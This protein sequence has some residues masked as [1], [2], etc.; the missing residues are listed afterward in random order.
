MTTEEKPLEL[1][2]VGYLSLEGH[3]NPLLFQE[4]KLRASQTYLSFTQGFETNHGLHF[5]SF[6]WCF[7]SV[8][9]GGKKPPAIARMIFLS[10]EVLTNEEAAIADL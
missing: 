3:H 4:K 9:S 8:S 10:Y 5:R 2:P 7:N 1:C 6:Y